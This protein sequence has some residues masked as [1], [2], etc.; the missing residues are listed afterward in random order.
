MWIEFNPNPC[1]KR[2]GDCSIRAISV[3]LD[4]SWDS[5]YMALAEHG[6]ALCDMPSSNSVIGSFLRKHGFIRHAIEN[7]CPE[8]YTVKD[9]CMDYPEGVY[10]LATGSHVVGVIS[11]NYYDSWDSGDEVPICF[12][13]K[14]E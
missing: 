2:V 6:Y 14:G 3:V 5:V 8:C 12:Y 1:N 10:V 4:K 13:A 11:G 7:S 9:F